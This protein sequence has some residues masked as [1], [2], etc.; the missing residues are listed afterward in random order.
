M[1][2]IFPALFP[3]LIL[4]LCGCGQTPLGSSSIGNQAPFDQYVNRPIVLVS[5]V[6]VCYEDRAHTRSN[7]TFKRGEMYYFCSGTDGGEVAFD[8]PAGT[9]LIVKKVLY[10]SNSTDNNIVAVGEIYIRDL[11]KNVP[12]DQYWSFYSEA[13]HAYALIRTP[14]EPLDTPNKRVLKTGLLPNQ[15]MGIKESGRK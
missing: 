9:P 13:E 4:C 3:V 15:Y 8:A 5:P 2:K 11:N 14:W 7:Q 6:K 1:Q 10:L 12:F